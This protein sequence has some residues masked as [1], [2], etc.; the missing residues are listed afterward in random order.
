VSVATSTAPRYLSTET[1]V[2]LYFWLI[3]LK[4]DVLQKRCGPFLKDFLI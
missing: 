1:H 2:Q 3:W 4:R